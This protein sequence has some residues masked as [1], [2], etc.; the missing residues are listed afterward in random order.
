MR[1]GAKGA[2][3]SLGAWIVR[4]CLCRRSCSFVVAVART[5]GA[6]RIEVSADSF[7]V[8]GS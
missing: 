8:E 4:V 6:V 1:R 5:A 2:R 7:V 3:R